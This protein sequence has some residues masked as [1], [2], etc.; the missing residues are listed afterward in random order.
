MQRLC[1]LCLL[2]AAKYWIARKQYR[3]LRVFVELGTCGRSST[4]KEAEH[5]QE[6]YY[7]VDWLFFGMFGPHPSH[8]EQEEL[9]LRDILHQKLSQ[10]Y[11]QTMSYGFD[12]DVRV[13]AFN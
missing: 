4:T 10:V 8:S 13:S 7:G 9:M 5:R 11:F 1:F 2:Y 3:W 6:S 12:V